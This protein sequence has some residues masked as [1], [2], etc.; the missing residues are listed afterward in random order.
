M[1][2]LRALTAANTKRWNAASVLPSRVAF[3][4]E[5][6]ER[7]LAAKT[8]YEAVAS[9]TGVPWPVVAVIHEREASQS[10]T[11]S[12]AQGDPWNKVSIHVPKGIGPFKSW[13]GAAVYALGNCAPFA[14]KWT[15]WTIGGA[16][17]LTLLYN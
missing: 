14:S 7:L 17:T 12:L 15:D 2:D 9:R 3:V 13:E 6:A 8:E 16:L 4:D 11:A 1:I 10:W 5:I